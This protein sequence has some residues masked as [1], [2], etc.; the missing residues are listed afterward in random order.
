M[1]TLPQRCEWLVFCPSILIHSLYDDFLV[2]SFHRVSQKVSGREGVRPGEGSEEYRIAP[3][4]AASP[5]MA[6][7]NA[8]LNTLLPGKGFS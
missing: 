1:P 4:T 8:P 3:D 2:E 5:P 6:V 7:Q